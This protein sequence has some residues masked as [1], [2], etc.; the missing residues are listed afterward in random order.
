MTTA[1]KKRKASIEDLAH[2]LCYFHFWTLDEINPTPAG[3]ERGNAIKK[4]FQATLD[5]FRDKAD[6]LWAVY[7]RRKDDKRRGSD[8]NA[9]LPWLKSCAEQMDRLVKALEK[10][11]SWAQER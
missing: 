7:N 5:Y 8:P 1:T 2:D 3:E 6:T 9:P 10:E 11:N 4:S